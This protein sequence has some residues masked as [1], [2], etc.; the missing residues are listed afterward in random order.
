M[1]HSCEPQQ[2]QH[3]RVCCNALVL[4]FPRR[5]DAQLNDIKALT[6]VRSALNLY[7][8]FAPLLSTIHHLF[9]T[10]T[11]GWRP[12]SNRASFLMMFPT[13]GR[14]AW[15]RRTSQ[16][17]RQLWLLT[18]ASA[19]E[20]LNLEEHT[21]RLSKALTLCSQSSVNLRAIIIQA[22]LSA[23]VPP[24]QMRQR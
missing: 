3:V 16:S 22:T 14:T 2:R 19:R 13:P 5:C 24:G 7:P 6:F 18:A 21:S 17:I 20:K 1:L 15:S 11:A 12:E 8:V 4:W 23:I 9:H 10:F